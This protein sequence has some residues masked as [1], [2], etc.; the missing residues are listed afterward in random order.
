MLARP[1]A[2]LMRALGVAV[3][4]P[5]SG[6]TLRAIHQGVL[7]DR[8]RLDGAAA[9]PELG[10]GSPRHPP[11][12][13]RTGSAGRSEP[14]DGGRSPLRRRVRAAALPG[15]STTQRGALGRSGLRFDEAE[16][17][18]PSPAGDGDQGQRRSPSSAR[19]AVRRDAGSG[20]RPERDRGPGPGARSRLVARRRALDGQSRRSRLS[21]GSAS[22]SGCDHR[23]YARRA[24]IPTTRAG[25]GHRWRSKRP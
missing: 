22:S 1:A 24:T 6:A 7:T 2:R 14:A 4:T 18:R 11:S 10:S 13:V 9:A 17:A 16:D 19:G 3:S 20:A 25:L 23:V 8:S 5:R 21:P 15:G 12:L